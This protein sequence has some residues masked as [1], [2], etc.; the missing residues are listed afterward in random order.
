MGRDF[1]VMRF[2][3]G[4]FIIFILI[5]FGWLIF[6]ETLTMQILLGILLVIGGVVLSIFYNKKRAV[7]LEEDTYG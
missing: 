4:I 5:F 7:L 2:I 1:G 6:G 3:V